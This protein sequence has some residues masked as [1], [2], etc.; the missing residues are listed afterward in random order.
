MLTLLRIMKHE[1]FIIFRITNFLSSVIWV[2][3]ELLL[4][5]FI[6][7]CLGSSWWVLTT[8]GNTR[9]PGNICVGAQVSSD[10]ISKASEFLYRSVFSGVLFISPALAA[11][12]YHLN[13]DRL[14][15]QLGIDTGYWH[16]TVSGGPGAERVSGD[17]DPVISQ[18]R[19]KYRPGQH[20]IN[21]DQNKN[22]VYTFKHLFD[23]FRTNV[24]YWNFFMKKTLWYLKFELFF[25]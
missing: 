23:S 17:M 3:I 11:G 14:Q 5:S 25:S 9:Y 13:M 15:G 1:N 18:P 8:L 24:M 21:G 4:F 10:L 19:E 6:I 2:F 22:D 20:L 7:Y 16:Q 12:L